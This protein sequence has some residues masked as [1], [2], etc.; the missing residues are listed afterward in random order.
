MKKIICFRN[1][2]LGDYLI[3]IPALKLIKKNN[4]ECKI[5]YLSAK[6]N[7]VSKLPNIIEGNKIVDKF[8]YYDHNFWGLLKLFKYFKTKMFTKIYYIQ[9][10]PNIFRETRDYIYFYL[11]GVSKIYGFF[12]KRMNYLY[13]SETYQI[14]KR[15]NKKINKNEIYNLMSFKYKID[16]RI[17]N[18]KYITISIGGFSQPQV[19]SLKNWSRLLNLL[20]TNY[21]FKIVILGT[22]DD[23]KNSLELLKQN[24]KT[25]L[26]FCG[27]TNI[28]ELLNIIKFSELHITNDN[29][30]MHVASLFQKKT[31]CLFNNHD[32]IG[33]W[34]PANK[35]SK[36]LRSEE[37]VNSINPY[38]VF[39]KITQML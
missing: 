30:S 11:L 17:L 33:K 2:K 36:I 9:E 27:K 34:H 24:K 14:A 29:G 23:I 12:E 10:K 22:K 37:G 1:S 3:S 38:K 21:N 7:L 4:P 32:P 26:S 16:K 39:K 6:N 18:Y 13:N 20:S 15:I 25:L 19:W 28:N 31:L 8:I 35:N 5:F